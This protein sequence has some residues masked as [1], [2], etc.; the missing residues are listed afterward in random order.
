MSFFA[1]LM[2]GGWTAALAM[3]GF[4]ALNESGKLLRIR[5]GMAGW[6][7]SAAAVVRASEESLQQ[8]RGVAAR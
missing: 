8:D 6:L 1:E 7:E 4:L 2:I 3:F 5:R